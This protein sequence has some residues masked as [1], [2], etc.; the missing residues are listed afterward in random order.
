[1]K[2]RMLVEFI[3][4]LS[5]EIA[6]HV[7]STHFVNFEA[8]LL[9]IRQLESLLASHASAKPVKPKSFDVRNLLRENQETGMNSHS[10]VL[11]WQLP[12]FFSS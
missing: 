2:Q 9:K 11:S 3:D 8:T 5:P 4:R 10:L 6:F 7:K 1:M 12:V